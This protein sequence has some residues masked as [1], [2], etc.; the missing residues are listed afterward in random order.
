MNSCSGSTPAVRSHDVDLPQRHV[1]QL[2]S[3]DAPG[4]HIELA[5]R[6]YRLQITPQHGGVRLAGDEVAVTLAEKIMERIGTALLA[7][8]HA[9]EALIRDT[10]VS[11]IQD[12]LK[13]D[14]AYRLP[15][16]RQAL[17]P[18]SLSQV[19]FMNAVLRADR[20][21]I[22]GVGPTGTGK[23]HL[24]IAAGLNLVAESRFMRLIIT[25]PHLM[26]E[27]EVMTSAL[28]AETANDEQL[29][30]IEDVLH[31]LIGNETRRLIDQGVIEIMPLGRMRGRT[32]NHSFIVQPQLHRARR[33][34]EHERAQD[35]HGR[36]PPRPRLMH[37]GNR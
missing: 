17:R 7:T 32:F 13:H 21:L 2:L 3:G 19:A 23:T 30:P 5:V 31:E 28:R 35:A 33:S 22:F 27:G 9:D 20:P 25:R 16:L 18:M 24:A 10:A 8:G 34:P 6:P 1:A 36:H 4:R 26:M 12:A 29:T 14:L 11:V 15:G 37:G